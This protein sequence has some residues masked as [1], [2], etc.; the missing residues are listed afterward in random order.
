MQLNCKLTVVG[1]QWSV[2]NL[3]KSIS[4]IDEFIVSPMHWNRKTDVQVNCK[5]TAVGGQSSVV[6]CI[7]SFN[8]NQLILLYLPKW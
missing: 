6:N 7:T 4:M 2:V 5:L 8:P 1:G 3:I